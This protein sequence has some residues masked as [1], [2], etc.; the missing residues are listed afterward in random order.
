MYPETVPKFTGRWAIPWLEG[1]YFGQGHS[2]IGNG[3]LNRQFSL[4]K[5]D[6][7]YLFSYSH[8]M[9]HWT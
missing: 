4:L 9:G 3:S 2:N 6:P 8:I 7:S 5:E 1:K